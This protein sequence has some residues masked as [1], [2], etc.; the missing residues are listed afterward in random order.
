MQKLEDKVLE[1]LAED[2]DVEDPKK[3]WEEACKRGISIA[4]AVEYFSFLAC[5]VEVGM[6]FYNFR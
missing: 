2:D 6:I 1:L 4:T 5:A 3:D